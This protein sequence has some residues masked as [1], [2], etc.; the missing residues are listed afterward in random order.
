MSSESTELTSLEKG[1]LI[2]RELASS[3]GGL[4]AADIAQATGLNRTTVYRLSARLSRGGWVHR[5]GAGEVTELDIGP[6]MHGLALLV[7][8]KY[9]TDAQLRPI[10]EGLARSLSETVH[11]G[12]LDR[13]HV[14][15]VARAMPDDGLNL[16]APIGSRE[17]AHLAALGKAL[18]ATMPDDAVRERFVG[19]ELTVRTK[20]TIA[21][22]EALLKE[23]A[24]VRERGFAV[25]D[26]ESRIGVK[27][28]A[29]PVTGASGGGL[30]A[31]S[32][33]TVPQRLEGRRYEQ[34][35]E[36]VQSASRL[37]SVCFGSVSADAWRRRDADAVDAVPSTI[38]DRTSGQVSSSA[39]QR[40]ASGRARSGHRRE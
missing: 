24:I 32:V 15:H 27:C 7:T 1:L 10:I 40:D 23:L 26:E 11:V 38:T 6:A 33:T 2:L 14:V 3:E 21:T 4:S 30:F 17:S 28:I 31:I 37:A 13:D 19:R 34:V 20:N 39:R 16:A 9:D 12:T 5:L 18:L 36:A 35:V 25:D 22:V 29:A 8:N